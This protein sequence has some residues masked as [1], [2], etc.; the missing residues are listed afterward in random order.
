MV[1]RIFWF[2]PRIFISLHPYNKPSTICALNVDQT[3][4]KNNSLPFHLD[5]SISAVILS[6]AL[7][8]ML[9]LFCLFK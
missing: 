9:V 5:Y 4:R 6:C 7:M 2:W 8:L 1:N 3:A